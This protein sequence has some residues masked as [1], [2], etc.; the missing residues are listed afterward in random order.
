M[1]INYNKLY[2]CI[3]VSLILIVSGC[4]DDATPT[5]PQSAKKHIYAGVFC[6]YSELDNDVDVR[7]EIF[8]SPKIDFY[9]FEIN[10]IKYTS[11]I[12]SNSANYSFSTYSNPLTGNYDTINVTL[13][14]SEGALTGKITMPDSVYNIN[15]NQA[16][17]MLATDTLIVNWS[18]NKKSDFYKLSLRYQVGMN[19]NWYFDTLLTTN[20]VSITPEMI[21][22]FGTNKIVSVEVMPYNGIIP[23]SN[24]ICNINGAGTGFLYY[25]RPYKYKACFVNVINSK[26]IPTKK[27]K[28]YQPKDILMQKV[29]GFYRGNN[30]K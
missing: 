15:I 11:Y 6:Q 12:A 22:I 7:G 14:T 23:S 8:Y 27:T 13:N 4:E 9:D 5:V 1:T 26:H 10:T 3:I 30:E 21:D 28:Y 19:P 18:Q 24:S 2:G 25:N 16:D 29:H 20:K 17:S